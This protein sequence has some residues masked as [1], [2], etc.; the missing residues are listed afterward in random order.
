VCAAVTVPATVPR[1][2]PIHLLDPSAFDFAPIPSSGCPP[3][4]NTGSVAYWLTNA[5][6]GT[7]I[8][9]TLLSKKYVCTVCMHSMYVYSMYATPLSPLL[10]RHS[11]TGCWQQP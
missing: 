1:L 9:K 7:D 4:F 5:G 2:D 8:N 6:G 10:Y 3:P 11:I